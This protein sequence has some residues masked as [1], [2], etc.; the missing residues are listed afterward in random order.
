MAMYY[1]VDEALPLLLEHGTRLQFGTWMPPTAGENN[2]LVGVLRNDTH[3][4]AL[5][6][7]NKETFKS[8][9]RAY[10]GWDWHVFAVYRVPKRILAPIGQSSMPTD[11]L[12]P[13]S[14][15]DALD[16]DEL[17][18]STKTEES[19]GFGIQQKMLA[20]ATKDP[21][22]FSELFARYHNYDVGTESSKTSTELESITKRFTKQPAR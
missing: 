11:R 2:I 9:S 20:C 5:D 19:D 15:D 21:E 12:A 18:Y 10:A 13:L 7:T 22:K 8:V 4:I 1:Q 17:L 16:L 14:K 3:A 6:V